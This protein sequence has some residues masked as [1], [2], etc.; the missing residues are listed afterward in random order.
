M[1]I[2][3]YEYL[4]FLLY[5]Y[6]IIPYAPLIQD[7]EDFRE[8]DG[9]IYLDFTFRNFI[10]A[11]IHYTP[12][13]LSF[14]RDISVLSNIVAWIHSTS[15]KSVKKADLQTGLY[16]FYE[17]MSYVFYKKSYIVHEDDKDPNYFDGLSIR[18]SHSLEEETGLLV[19]NHLSF[20]NIETLDIDFETESLQIR[21]VL[22]LGNSDTYGTTYADSIRIKYKDLDMIPILLQDTKRFYYFVI[23]CILHKYSKTG[24]LINIIMKG[25]LE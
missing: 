4:P 25:D 21:E 8:V 10:L 7:L 20:E 16:W 3:S 1:I 5:S 18:F 2:A 15:F 6:D 24:K 17:D 14:E 12:M 13:H 19:D 9:N 23:S 22:E 11:N